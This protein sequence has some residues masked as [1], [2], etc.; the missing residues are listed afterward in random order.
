MQEL[1]EPPLLPPSRKLRLDLTPVKPLLNHLDSFT[2][3]SEERELTFEE[4]ALAVYILKS[5]V[6]PDSLDMAKCVEHFL[7]PH[8]RRKR[9]LGHWYLYARHLAKHFA[10]GE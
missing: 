7:N 1:A 8:Y 4:D 5:L 2:E 3:K 6:P 9:T 10:Y